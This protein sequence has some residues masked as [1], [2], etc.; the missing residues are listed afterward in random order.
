M[1]ENRHH[2]AHTH[3]A[4]ELNI[5]IEND[6]VLIE[7]ESPA[8]NL[9]GFEHKPRTDAQQLE[10]QKALALLNDVEIIVSF[11]KGECRVTETHIRGPFDNADQEEPEHGKRE[12]HSEFHATYSL[13]C[14]DASVIGSVSTRLFD[15]FPGF[16]AIRVRWVGS[17]G[18]GSALLNNQSTIFSIE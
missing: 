14:Q 9:I 11:E 16:E 12:E 10:L 4:A 18:Q 7:F 17:K 15:H 2:D 5:V 6:T 1:A 3:G 8:V 13:S